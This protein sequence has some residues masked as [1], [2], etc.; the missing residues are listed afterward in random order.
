VL[1]GNLYDG[2]DRWAVL[3]HDEGS[4]CDCWRSLVVPLANIGL[5]PLAFDLRGHGVS[6]DPWEPGR[7][8]DDVLAALRF[9]HAEGASALFLLGAGVGA[10]AALVAAGRQEVGAL[11]L[12]SPRVGLAGVDADALRETTAPK[13]VVVGGHEPDAAAQASEVYRGSIGWGLLESPPVEEQGVDLLS[14]EWGEH[15]VEHTLAFLRDYL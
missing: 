6:D 4:D 13:L 12:Y 8:A 9:A 1:R 11:V 7:V 5:R 15:V 3:V 14:S 2:G 10:T